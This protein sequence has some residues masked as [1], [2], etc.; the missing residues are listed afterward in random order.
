MDAPVDEVFEGEDADEDGELGGFG[1]ALLEG[2]ALEEGGFAAAGVADDD[3][4]AVSGEGLFEQGGAVFAE[5]VRFV[6]RDSV[7]AAARRAQGDVD[8]FDGQTGGFAAAD[9]EAADIDIGA[10]VVQP[11]EVGGGVD[12]RR[13]VQGSRPRSVASASSLWR[14]LRATDSSMQSPASALR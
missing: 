10:V 14:I 3:E 4:F 12:G 1:A 7:L 5:G 8:L 2:E 13:R 6:V 11:G 9:D